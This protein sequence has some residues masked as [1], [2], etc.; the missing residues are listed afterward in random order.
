MS[1][2]ALKI[3]VLL[4]IFLGEF[5]VIYAEIRASNTYS[6]PGQSFG[7]VF[8]AMFPVFLV[9]GALL[10]SG[11]ILGYRAFQNIWI[12]TAIS[13]TSVLVVEPLLAFTIFQ[14]VP[15]RGAWLGLGFGTAGLLSALLL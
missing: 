7:R 9:G 15:T 13:I 3:L 1:G 12:V 6:L 8:L 10:M 5:F 2:N 4:L 14:Q 11:Y